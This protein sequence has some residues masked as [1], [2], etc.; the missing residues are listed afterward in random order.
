MTAIEISVQGVEQ[1]IAN[2]NSLNSELLSAA[3]TA[4]LETSED[5]RGDI[6]E[7]MPVDTGW[8]Q[9]RWGEPMYG[10]VWEFEDNGLSLTQGS[11][12]EPYEYIERLNEGSSQQAP[13]GFI[14]TAAA[15]GGLKLEANLS[16]EL[17]DAIGKYA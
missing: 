15:R 13:A 7:A 4:V 6:Q 3:Q 11:D 9:A 16:S 17:D 1:T 14:D 5:V 12:I 8:A 10:G 2:L